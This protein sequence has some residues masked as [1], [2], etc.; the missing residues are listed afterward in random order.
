[1]GGISSLEQFEQ[2]FANWGLT[3]K[4]LKMRSLIDMVRILFD[5]GI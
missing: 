1:V 3:G 5:E 4:I 2:P